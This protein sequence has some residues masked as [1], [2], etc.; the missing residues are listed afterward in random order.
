MDRGATVRTT[1]P[2][3]PRTRGGRA[4]E[5]A[6]PDPPPCRRTTSTTARPRAT[7]SHRGHPRRIGENRRSPRRGR[8]TS[9]P[10]GTATCISV[11]RTVGSGVRATD[12]HRHRRLGHA[13][14][15]PQRGRSRR[16]RRPDRSRRN[17]Q[18]GRSR[19]SR[20]PD[21]NL[22]SP[23]RDRSRR[24]RRCVPRPHDP[25]R[26][27][28][29]ETTRRASEAT[30]A[31]TT[32]IGV[33]PDRRPV[34]RRH[35]DD[36]AETVRETQCGASTAGDIET[37]VAGRIASVGCGAAACGEDSRSAVQVCRMLTARSARSCRPGEPCP[38]T[39]CRVLHM[40]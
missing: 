6:R 22:R 11:R 20:R 5:R 37:D 14:G 15:N 17:P 28:S 36:S 32:S 10:T 33:R 26:A 19:R 18:R 7:A 31:S 1:R 4:R 24:S 8:T 30:P 12:G 34:R 40:N 27:G 39:S 38:R 3:R 16:S 25:P 9:S 21:R 23:R 13:L 35:G 2:G 29:S